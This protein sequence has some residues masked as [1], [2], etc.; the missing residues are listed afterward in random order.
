MLEIRYTGADTSYTGWYGQKP[1]SKFRGVEG[2]ILAK[3]KRKKEGKERRKM[4]YN[5]A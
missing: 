5:D 3:K 4:R 1:R 2:N